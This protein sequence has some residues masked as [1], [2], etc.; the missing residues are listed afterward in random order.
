V[1]GV[2][3]GGYYRPMR[4]ARMGRDTEPTPNPPRDKPN[5]MLGRH[6]DMTLPRA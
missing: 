6:A 3:A 2:D 4:L 1:V 5:V